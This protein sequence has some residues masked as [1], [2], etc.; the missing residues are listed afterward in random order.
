MRANARNAAR[1]V[2]PGKAANAANA[3]KTMRTPRRAFTLIELLVV[4]ALTSILLTVVFKP[5]VNSLD[6]TRLAA[7]QT[8]TQAGARQVTSEVN[9]SL[10]LAEYVM[11]NSAAAP[12]NLWL[13]DKAGNPYFLQ[14]NYT[15]MEYIPAAHQLD[16]TPYINAGTNLPIDPTTGLPSYQFPGVTAAQSGPAI[17]LTNGII[18]GRL[19]LGLVN[20]VSGPPSVVNTNGTPVHPYFNFYEW[21]NTASADPNKPGNKSLNDH[22]AFTLYRAEVPT[23]IPDPNVPGP[24]YNYIPNLMLFHTGTN[25]NAPVDTRTAPLLVHDPNFF[26]DNSLAGGNEPGAGTTLWAVPGW[27]DLNKDGKVEIWENWRAEASSLVRTDKVDLMAFQRDSLTNGIVYDALN[28]P[29]VSPL[30]TFKPAFVQNDPAVATSLE[31]AGNEVPNAASANFTSQFDHWAYNYRVF[32]YRSDGS[33]KDPTQRNPLDYYEGISFPNGATKIV[34]IDPTLAVKP[35]DPPPDPTSATYPDVSGQFANGEFTQPGQF[36]FS[37][38]PNKGLVSFS[39]PST[40]VIHDSAGAPLAQRYSPDDINNAYSAFGPLGPGARRFLSLTQLPT[41]NWGGSPLNPATIPASPLG[42]GPAN[43]W[44]TPSI[45]PGTELVFGPDQ[46]PGV[47]YGFRIQY[48]RVSSA[49]GFTGPNQ[50]KIN[51]T[52]NANIPGGLGG[53]PPSLLAGYIEFDS[54]PDGVNY[55]S[56]TFTGGGSGLD[57]TTNR[58]AAGSHMLPIYKFNT[59]TMSVD[60]TKVSDPVE[61]YYNFQMNQP[62]DVIKI[63][64]MTRALMIFS[65]EM[66]LYDPT[67]GK[68]QVTR[69]TDKIKV[70]NLQH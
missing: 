27:K 5:L 69:L 13:T 47:H 38:S 51:F 36:S 12:L 64:Y 45:V 37:P 62:G 63:D 52:N 24:P 59:A 56:G 70:R 54:V 22:N 19:F 7:T 21:A 41:T 26:Y 32:V 8:E 60:G 65:L 31:E 30:A 67:S 33:G 11:D 2:R 58:P 35:G 48:S 28:H 14:T 1:F 68:P 9:N 29:I 23:Y 10:S 18:L 39:Y 17:P 50:Y 4:I 42:P 46:R 43:T 49:S 20:N 16:Q 6:L 55:N 44:V 40:S 3:A 34:H 25:I 15:M 53:A 57:P 66:R 61:V